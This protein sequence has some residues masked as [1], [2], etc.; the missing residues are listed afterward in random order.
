[1]LQ[2]IVSF[3]L[4]TSW[5]PRAWRKGSLLGVS[6]L[7]LM[8]AAWLLPPAPV[9][10]QTTVNYDFEDGVM[11]GTP[12]RMKVPP[13]II[14]ENGNKFM[15]ITGSTGDC[16]SVPSS[17]CPPRNRSTVAFTSHA[18]SMP[19]ITSANMR[20]TYS[21]RIRFHDDTGSDGYVFELFQ[22]SPDSETYGA[23]NGTGPVARFRRIDGHVYA[24]LLYDN[25]N[26][27]NYIDLGAIKSGTFHTYGFKAVWSHDPSVGRLEVYLDGKLKKTITGRDVNLGPRSNRL[28]MMKLGLYGDYAVG[29]IDVDNVKA[30]PSSSSSPAPSVAL[31]GPANVQLVSGQ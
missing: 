17:K 31:S 11:R 5:S 20:Q 22:D 4:P 29:R 14:T 1:M 2:R 28:P 21:A 18:S 27:Q 13:K 12:T 26:K 15:R 16:Q 25:E 6:C 23:H 19:L 7:A 3:A 8:G 9:H 24:Q 10:A 30:G